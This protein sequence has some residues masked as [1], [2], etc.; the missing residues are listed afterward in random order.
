MERLT[1]YRWPGNVRQ[2]QHVIER[3][4]SFAA[5]RDRLYLGTSSFRNWLSRPRPAFSRRDIALSGFNFENI[6]GQVERL[7]IQ[8]ALRRCD[9]NKAK[10]ARALGLKRTTMLY[11]SKVHAAAS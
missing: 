9:G 10:A 1:A 8:E 3:A 2:L 5:K 6:I 7:L 4:V 11:K